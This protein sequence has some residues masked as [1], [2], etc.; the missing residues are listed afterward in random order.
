MRLTSL[1]EGTKVGVACT[2]WTGSEN[3]KLSIEKAG[4]KHLRLILGCSQ[5]KE[6]LRKM[7]KDPNY[8]QDSRQ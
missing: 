6:S 3:M 2:D 7:L 5:E 8:H 4:L 1:P